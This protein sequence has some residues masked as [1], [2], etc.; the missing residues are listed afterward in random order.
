MSHEIT[1]RRD[2][3]A[4]A[5][6]AMTPAWHG[7]GTVVQHAMTSDEAIIEGGLDWPVREVPLFARV[8]NSMPVKEWES[9]IAGFTDHQVPNQWAIVRTDIPSILGICGTHYRVIQN[10]EAFD[11]VDS[12]YQDG[13][14]KYESVGSLKGGKIVWLLARMPEDFILASGDPLRKYILFSTS[15]NGSGAIRC[16]PTSVRVVCWNTYTMATKRENFG[17]SIRHRGDLK[18]KMAE[19]RD[20]IRGIGR[21][22]DNYHAAAGKLVEQKID[23]RKLDAYLNILIPNK[24]NLNNTYRAAVRAQIMAAFHDDPQMLP[25]VRDTAWAAFSAVTQVIDH[26]STYRARTCNRAENRMISTMFGN[27]AGLKRSAFALAGKVFAA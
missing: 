9:H 16:L 2:G 10:R 13:I 11:F 3:R 1:I 22:F 21:E 7:L 24:E 6:Y 8:P 12:L 18:T 14:I 20:V 27:N 26:N 19:A 5:A 25:S 23:E 17:V 4:E 15:H